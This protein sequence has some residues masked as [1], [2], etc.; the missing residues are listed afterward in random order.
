MRRGAQGGARDLAEPNWPVREIPWRLEVRAPATPKARALVKVICTATGAVPDAPDWFVH[1][2]EA[3]A[4]AALDRFGKE[5]L[6]Q[7]RGGDE[8]TERARRIL[9]RLVDRMEKEAREQ[10]LLWTPRIDRVRDMMAPLTEPQKH[11]DENHTRPLTRWISEQTDVQ[12]LKDLQEASMCRVVHRGIAR[13]ACVLDRELIRP[14]LADPDWA[15]AW[16][17]NKAL[18]GEVRDW[19]FDEV[20]QR[21]ASEKVGA[22]IGG[23]WHWTATCLVERHTPTGKRMDAVV[24]DAE[25][26]S[27]LTSKLLTRVPLTRSRFDR[28]FQAAQVSTKA[29][30]Q[31][32]AHEHL[33]ADH[34]WRLWRKRPRVEIGLALLD[35][36]SLDMPR[37]LR[38]AIARKKSVKL[39]R[40]LWRTA[41]D[42]GAF[43]DAFRA[44][45]RISSHEAVRS[46]LGE[47][48]E[49][50]SAL[51]V[52][53][54]SRALTH[55]D[56]AVRADAIQAAAFLGERTRKPS[57]AR[58]G[59][60]SE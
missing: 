32:A 43:A 29:A 28:L 22:Y 46:L 36:E 57:A 10:Q 30:A 31:A 1:P 5:M 42:P 2:D 16:T 14:D 11:I 40:A 18:G 7:Y 39:A 21:R 35:N 23:S 60:R 15:I 50:A 6:D 47:S 56:R 19:F 12:R 51:S 38:D 54:L 4:C 45:F 55:S 27:T 41:P 49:R 8:R 58:T 59:R 3:V 44:L 33:G 48:P 37:E 52:D 26:D 13:H 25:G 9:A 34:A 17:A 24:H 53:D 20:W